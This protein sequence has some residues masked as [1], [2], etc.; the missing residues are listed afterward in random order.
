VFLFFSFLFLLINWDMIGWV[1]LDPPN[2]A[3]L[4]EEVSY[5]YL[6]HM[7]LVSVYEPMNYLFRCNSRYLTVRM[8]G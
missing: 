1:L 6:Y 4:D 5:V 3:P 2:F 7:C 8:A